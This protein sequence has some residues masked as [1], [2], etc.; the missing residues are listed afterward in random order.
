VWGDIAQ[1][2]DGSG[3]LTVRRSKTDPAAA[4]S[5]LYLSPQA[6]QNL[7]AIRPPGARAADRV[8][9]LGGAQINRRIQ[10]AAQ[11]AGLRT[12]FSGHSARVGMAQDL[13]AAGATLAEL[14]QAGR[15]QSSSMPALYTR[16]QAAGRR[17][18]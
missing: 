3:R 14:M 6:V 4:G 7:Q 1:A 18:S 8:F 16:S 5:V 12:G 9:G 15:W 17:P 10:A 11:A 13:A 2:A